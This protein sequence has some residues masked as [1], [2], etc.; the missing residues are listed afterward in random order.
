MLTQLCS[1]AHTGTVSFQDNG[2]SIEVIVDRA[3]EDPRY[4][5]LEIM[6][7]KPVESIDH[8][9]NFYVWI[10]AAEFRPAIADDIARSV[11]IAGKQVRYEYVQSLAIALGKQMSEPPRLLPKEWIFPWGGRHDTRLLINALCLRCMYH[12]VAVHFWRRP[13]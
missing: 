1:A 5:A 9:A 6:G 8:S 2:A 3:Q 4:A 12:L 10:R 13:Q 11:R 7:Y